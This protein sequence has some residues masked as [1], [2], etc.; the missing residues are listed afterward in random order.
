[1]RERGEERR[2]RSRESA[3]ERESGK[4]GRQT[5]S[6]AS[7]DENLALRHKCLLDRNVIRPNQ[8]PHL[9]R[10]LLSDPLSN[11]R[12]PSQGRGKGEG[13]R[14]KEEEEEDGEGEEGVHHYESGAVGMTEK[15]GAMF[16][17]RSSEERRRATRE[18]DISEFEEG[19]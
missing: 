5:D 11:E 1:M 19:V 18:T 8:L 15:D 4:N 17:S 12:L 13:G 14:E 16:K 2:R 9:N 6:P 3:C 10:P 7:Y